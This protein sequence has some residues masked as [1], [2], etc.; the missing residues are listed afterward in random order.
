MIMDLAYLEQL[1]QELTLAING[2]HSAF[3][4]PIM[5]FFSNK[6]VWI[7]MYE[8]IVA[9]MLW[10]LGWKKTLVVLAGVVLTIVLCDQF[11]NIV[12]HWAQRIRPVNDPSMV[13]RG[14]HILETGGGYSFFSAHAA[15]SFSIALCTIMPLR[16]HAGRGWDIRRVS[17]PV[18]DKS[19][20]WIRFYTWWML[21]WAFMVAVSRIFVGKHF[22]GDVIVGTMVGILL[23][24]AMGFLTNLAIRKLVR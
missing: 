7:P 1:D 12:K 5:W 20:G 3:T 21:F 11:A 14:L 4:D 17:S 22:L 13:E 23:G 16:R 9:L 10:K 2:F 19:A 6:L 18:Q 15:N 24:L 8:G